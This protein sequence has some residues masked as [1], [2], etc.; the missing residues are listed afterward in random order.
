MLKL[1]EKIF[2]V[3]MLFYTTG[4]VLPQ[5]IGAGSGLSRVEGNPLAL[6]VQLALYS[7]AF[8]FIV[9]G[10]RSFLHWTWGAR[11]IVAL[12]LVA[13][14]SVL[15]SQDPSFTLRRSL[16]LSATT[17][18]G[19]YFGS[20]YTLVEQLRMLA[21]TCAL[22]VI[23]CFIFGFLFP[24]Y[25]IDHV[26][27]PGDW[28]GAFIQ[29]NSLA[30]AMVF[31][32]FVFYFVRPTSFAWLRWVGVAAS[33]SLLLLSKSVTG[34]VVLAIAASALPF[35]HLVRK[36]L[37]ILVPLG[38]VTALLVIGAA[39]FLAAYG[40]D[41]LLLLHRSPTLTDRTELWQAVLMSIS[42]RPWGGYGFNA[43]WMGMQGESAA[44]MV[45]VGW[46]PKHAHNGFLD[47]LLDLGILGLCTFLVGYLSLWSKTLRLLRSA[48]GHYPVWL[49]I[50]MVFMF[51]YN[52]TESSILVQNNLFWLLYVSAA[53][54]L[55]ALFPQKSLS[56]QGVSQYEFQFHSY[57]LQ[58]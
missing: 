57:C 18:F 40:R 55:A 54:T 45:R 19:V 52:L 9:L 34:I 47:L 23:S 39:A 12:S 22:V 2:T 28:Q 56:S 8:V 46:F 30:R 21:W 35:F 36:R 6:A 4:A 29:K 26:V 48:A 1:V 13:V 44:V 10:W 41:L 43:F 24:K 32:V 50:Y 49:C 51:I 25:G 31:S 11:W 14:V 38:V 15:W 7:A 42:K 20:R 53:S 37:S 3:A 58:G 16:V 5:L 27:H 17:A 33:L